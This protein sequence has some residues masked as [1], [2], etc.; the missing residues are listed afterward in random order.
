MGRHGP[1]NTSADTNST[2][3]EMKKMGGEEAASS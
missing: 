1:D 2:R 3:T